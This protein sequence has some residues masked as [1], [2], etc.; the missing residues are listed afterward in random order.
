MP[1]PSLNIKAKILITGGSGLV[2][3]LL[4]SLLLAE[5]YSVSHLSRGQDKFGR[6]RVHRWDPEKGILDPAVLDG[7]DYIIHLAGANI[8]KKRWSEKRRKKIVSSRVDSLSLLHRIVVENNIPLKAL[9]SA[10]A[11]GYYGSATT[12]KIFTE[13]DPPGADFLASTCRQWEEAADAFGKS[14]IRT[15]KIRSAVVLDQ[16]DSAL[17]RL[18]M[19]AKFGFI[20]RLG[21]G[22]QYMPWIHISDLC[23]IYLKAVEDQDL[24]GAFN[25]VSPQH[26]T[27]CE[28]INTLSLIIKKPVFPVNVPSFILSSV[29]GEMSS[30]VLRGSR[31]SS[32]RISETGFKFA[33]GNLNDALAALLKE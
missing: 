32:E 12:E 1:G 16:N 26:V 25:A 27:H 8:G 7:I 31:I 11:A 18:M 20:V 29:L 6:V 24:S 15:V 21:N 5:G 23:G 10:S 14:G 19:P 33:Y 3:R 4:T 28:F 17:R 22:R 2:G 30:V 9:I 13:K